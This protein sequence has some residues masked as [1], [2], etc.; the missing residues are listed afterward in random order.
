MCFVVYFFE[1]TF[2]FSPAQE[3][4]YHSSSKPV[5][6]H[7][8][9]L[10]FSV[11]KFVLSKVDIV[12]TSK[13][14]TWNLAMYGLNLSLLRRDRTYGRQKK[15]KRPPVQVVYYVHAHISLCLNDLP[16]GILEG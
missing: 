11:L 10:L 12:I 3:E 4:L 5:S 8:Y 6:F 15:F 7:C 1:N 9:K 2:I 14:I 13:N 16:C